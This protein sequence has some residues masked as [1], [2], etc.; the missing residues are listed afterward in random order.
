[1]LARGVACSSETALRAG[2]ALLGLLGGGEQRLGAAENLL[3]VLPDGGLIDRLIA[4]WTA[5]TEELGGGRGELHLDRCALGGRR[6]RLSRF[7][8]LTL[9]MLDQRLGILKQLGESPLRRTQLFDTP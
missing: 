4:Y 9:R 5:I 8:Q 7:G 6:R 3:Q 2:E 1:M